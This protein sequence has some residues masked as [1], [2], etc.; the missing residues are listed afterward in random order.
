MARTDRSLHDTG[1]LYAP[2]AFTYDADNFLVSAERYPGTATAT[3]RCR[4]WPKS[5]VDVPMPQGRSPRDIMDTTD[6]LV[7]KNS[8]D[9][10]AGWYFKLTTSGHPD[11]GQWFKI[12]GNAQNLTFRA[13]TRRFLMKKGIAPPRG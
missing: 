4:V 6:V 7:L 13:G 8:T 1:E 5:E 9:C 12:L 10:G 11:Q 3:V 2:S